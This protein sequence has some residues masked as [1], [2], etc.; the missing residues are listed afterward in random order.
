[1]GTKYVNHSFQINSHSS[2]N[3]DV[4]LSLL[5]VKEPTVW[6]VT[7]G[8]KNAYVHVFLNFANG[9]SETCTA[10][11][12]FSMFKPTASLLRT[13]IYGA[14][15]IW[16]NCWNPD[17]FGW[18]GEIGVG[19]TTYMPNSMYFDGG[20]YSDY[21]GDAKWIQIMDINCTGWFFI[22]FL[23]V[24]NPNADGLLDSSDPYRGEFQIF[25]K[26]NPVSTPEHHA[27]Y[28]PLDDA[29]AALSYIDEEPIEFIRLNYHY[30]DH[31]MFKPKDGIWVPL[32]ITTWDVE[33]NINWPSTNLS[34]CSV[35]PPDSISD[36][37]DFPVWTSK[38][39]SPGN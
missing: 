7:K 16:L 19:E 14:K 36:S 11:G 8:T 10:S 25:A 6:Y 24:L 37:I 5:D 28:V 22:N 2:V 23:P 32:G 31:L 13:D 35:T 34:G 15:V 38:G 18:N 39:W 33:A 4:D 1:L 21:E 3:W 20:I 27:N 9:Q 29:P 12:K 17:D 30:T 26:V